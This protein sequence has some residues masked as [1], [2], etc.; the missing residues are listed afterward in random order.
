MSGPTCRACQESK[1]EHSALKIFMWF[2]A[3]LWYAQV[4]EFLMAQSI[5]RTQMQAS[6]YKSII[7]KYI[8]QPRKKKRDH[9]CIQV[10]KIV[11]TRE[12]DKAQDCACMN[13]SHFEMVKV[14]IHQSPQL[15]STCPYWLCAA[16]SKT[17]PLCRVPNCRIDLYN[18]NF[19][20]L[21]LSHKATLG[22]TD[23]RENKSNDSLQC[24]K[25]VTPKCATLLCFRTSRAA[26]PLPPPH[27]KTL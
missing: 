22:P 3:D 12:S 23:E 13:L 1:S 14:V 17:L 5:Q 21:Q 4:W 7:L 6:Q 26:P 19:T 18:E 24:S 27:I 10:T 15:R 2:R 8:E 11:V 25:S 9:P 20:H 16:M